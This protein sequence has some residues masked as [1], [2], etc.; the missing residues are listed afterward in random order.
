VE[1][2][3]TSVPPHVLVNMQDIVPEHDERGAGSVLG[4]AGQVPSMTME[5]VPVPLQKTVSLAP[6]AEL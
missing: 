5:T 1:Q 4:H 2:D 6:H 3:A